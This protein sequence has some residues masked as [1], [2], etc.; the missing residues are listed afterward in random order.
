MALKASS[1]SIVG[2][3]RV[4]ASTKL[5]SLNWPP[6][7]SS[8]RPT[9]LSVV[10]PAERTSTS[11]K[12]W[13]QC[14]MNFHEHWFQVWYVPEVDTRRSLSCLSSAM[15]VHEGAR[16]IRSHR[17][18]LP[19]T[20]HFHQQASRARARGVSWSLI[21]HG[22]CKHAARAQLSFHLLY[23]ERCESAL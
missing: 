16:R 11:I 1:G 20:T 14:C 12:V 15:T 3:V 6:L 22:L 18:L 19:T 17:F 7:V 10:S 8:P 5:R 9:L 4:D 21:I 2:T 23:S 13:I